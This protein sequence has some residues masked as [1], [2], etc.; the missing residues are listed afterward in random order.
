MKAEEIAK[1]AFNIGKLHERGE[2]D[3]DLSKPQKMIKNYA[4]QKCKEQKQICK[5]HATGFQN[6]GLARKRIIEAPEPDME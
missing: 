2:V 1:I 5:E 3:Y 4:K 6:D